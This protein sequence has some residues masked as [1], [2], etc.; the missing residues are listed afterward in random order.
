MQEC[1]TILCVKLCEFNEPS[2][3][4]FKSSFELNQKYG[5][6]F[7]SNVCLNQT[8]HAVSDSRQRVH[9]YS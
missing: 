2:H 4:R 7:Y 3:L 5:K 8:R 1:K 6:N 9:A